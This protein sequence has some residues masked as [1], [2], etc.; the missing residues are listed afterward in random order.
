MSRM[1][2]HAHWLQCR[3]F[4]Q[5]HNCGGSP[6]LSCS[7]ALLVLR[8]RAHAP[9]MSA[10]QPGLTRRGTSPIPLWL[11]GVSRGLSCQGQPWVHVQPSPFAF[12][13][14]LTAAPHPFRGFLTQ[15][16]LLPGQAPQ[17]RHTWAQSILAPVNLTQWAA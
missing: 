3:P 17:E 8:M 9:G 7:V 16:L 15:R 10:E 4:G 14:L 2:T 6:S 1:A 5:V 11:A 13:F 12:V